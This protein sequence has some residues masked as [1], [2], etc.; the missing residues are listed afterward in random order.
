MKTYKTGG[1][2]ILNRGNFLH[3][4]INIAKFYIGIN[5]CGQGA[6]ASIQ[7]SLQMLAE[8]FL[9]CRR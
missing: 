1:E 3:S 5:Q 2:D 6:G 4:N 9:F 8:N 7:G